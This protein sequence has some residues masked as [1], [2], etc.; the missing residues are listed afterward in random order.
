MH[1]AHDN[2]VWLVFD[3]VFANR[4]EIPCHTPNKSS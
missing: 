1:N 4:K 3:N 2:E